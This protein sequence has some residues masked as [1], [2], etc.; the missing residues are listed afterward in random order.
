M[1]NGRFIDTAKETKELNDVLL[2]QKLGVLLKDK[3]C[4]KCDKNCVL[5]YRFRNKTSTNRLIN[6]RC[7]SCGATS[8]VFNGTFF[9]LFRKPVREIMIVIKCW[10]VELTIAKTI[11][12]LK[13]EDINIT[14]QTVGII[15]NHLRNV[16][17]VALD[18]KNIKLGG[19]N[20]IIEIDESLY[21]RVKHTVGKD[22]MRQQVWCYG[23]V[24]RKSDNCFLQL[25]PNRKA[26][27]LLSITYEH[28]Q[29]YSI[30]YSDQFSSYNKLCQLHDNT[31][32]HSTVNHSLNFVDPETLTCTNKV[33]SYW[34]ACKIKFKEMRGCQRMLIQGYIDEFMWRKNF[35]IARFEDCKILSTK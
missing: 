16:C 20:L 4:I 5:R 31:L 26:D 10:A 35:K 30:I 29:P 18:K 7:N 1:E 23:M 6:W 9:Q 24:D 13:L 3:K 2:L 19:K 34:N 8:S 17:T 32:V 25:V 12:V 33:E 27:T 11:H 28:S 22:L 15:F 21:A 14:R